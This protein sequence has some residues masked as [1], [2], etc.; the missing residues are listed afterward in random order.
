MSLAAQLLLYISTIWC[1]MSVSLFDESM[2]AG[3]SVQLINT[4]VKMHMAC[5]GFV[6]T[7][8]IR[9]AQKEAVSFPDV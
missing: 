6:S 4:D 7:T 5:P 1:T 8:M 2:Q 9:R 3:V